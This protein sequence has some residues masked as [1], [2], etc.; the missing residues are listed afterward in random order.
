MYVYVCMYIVRT[1]SNGSTEIKLSLPFSTSPYTVCIVCMYVCVYVS[2]S[3]VQIVMGVSR[4]SLLLFS[5]SPYT[6]CI[7]CMCMYVCISYVQ[8]VMGVPR[9]SSRCPFLLAYILYVLYGMCV[10][11][12]VCRYVCMFSDQITVMRLA[13]PFST[14]SY[15]CVCMYVRI[16]ASMYVCMYV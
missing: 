15:V 2:M 1:N 8:I 14:R 4:S 3:Y 9:L 13:L 7:V 12:H 16:T 6:V 10:C 5:T 11:M